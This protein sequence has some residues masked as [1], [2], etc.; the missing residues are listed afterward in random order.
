MALQKQVNDG[1]QQMKEMIRDI[2]DIL[3]A[4]LSYV[5]K[6]KD[7]AKEMA[8]ENTT[9]ETVDRTLHKLIKKL[10]AGLEE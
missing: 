2:A 3:N 4:K 5:L 1:K 7:A 9:E 8:Q 10:S 6:V